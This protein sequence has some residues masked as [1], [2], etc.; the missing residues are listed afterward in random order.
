VF[1]QAATE[2]FSNQHNYIPRSRPIHFRAILIST[3]EQFKLHG[4]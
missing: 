3:L 4:Q 1:T 2:R